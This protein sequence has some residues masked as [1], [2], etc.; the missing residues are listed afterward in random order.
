MNIGP[1]KPLTRVAKIRQRAE[2][3]GLCFDHYSPGDSV[4][5]YRFGLPLNGCED[6]FGM[7]KF[8]TAIGARDAEL[9]LE[10]F[11]TAIRVLAFKLVEEDK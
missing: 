4:I 10:G 7:R 11:D 9:F 2:T 5:R 6:Y 3:L 1:L 8:H